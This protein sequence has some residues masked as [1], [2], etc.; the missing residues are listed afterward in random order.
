MTTATAARPAARTARELNAQPLARSLTFERG[1]VNVEQRTVELAF[2]SELPYERWFGIEILDHGAASVDLSR[3]QDGAALLVNHA[4][5]DQV[6]VIERAWIADDRRGRAVVRFGKSQRAEE[7]W[8]DV[9]DGIRRL[10][11]V[12]YRIDEAVLEKRDNKTGVDTYRVTRWTPYEISLVAVPADPS[13]GVGRAI[14]RNPVQPKEQ[15]VDDDTATTT[16]ASAAAQQTAAS[17]I[18]VRTIETGAASRAL[19]TERER[20]RAIR[21][22]GEQHGMQALASTAI[23]SGATLETFRATVLDKLVES[24]KLRPAESAEVGLSPTDLA[25]FSVRKLIAAVMFPADKEVQREAAFEIEVSNAARKKRPIEDGRPDSGARA[26][27]FSIPVDVLQAPMGMSNQALRA[28][29]ATQE[30]L[31]RLAASGQRDLLVGTASAGGNLV[32]TD[33]LSGNFIDLLRNALVVASVG[34]RMLTGLNG[35]V[36]IPTQ[37]GGASTFWVGENTAVTES[38]ATFGQVTMTPKTVGMFTDYSRRLLLQSSLDIEILVRMDLINGLAVEIDRAALNGSGTSN[39]PT[40]VLQQAGIGSV[41]GGTNGAAPTWDN[42]VDLESAVANANAAAGSLAYVTNTRV[43]GKLKRT[44]VFSGTNGQPIWGTDN[45]VNGYATGVSNNVPN[46]LTKGTSTSVC[47]A[48]I[49]G[50]WADLLIGMWSG[51]DLVLDPFT[52]ATAGTKR[53]VALQDVDVAVRRAVS[54]AAM[55]DALTT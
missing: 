31:R 45:R 49:F 21:A 44:Q 23:D 13:V 24:R 54:F 39:Q 27:G 41:V 53:V 12:G 30:L 22:L 4:S 7:I 26:A 46:T 28:A 48:I 40:G 43:R 42:V 34:A 33:L 32:A 19:Q 38:Q 14:E 52:G 5:G 29:E 20:V 35:N 6:G 36:A 17:A 9:Q 25:K 16:A 11:S 10:V 18:D 50:Q 3:M 1:A 8:Q 2:S 37:S 47:S 51:V 15:P 55:V